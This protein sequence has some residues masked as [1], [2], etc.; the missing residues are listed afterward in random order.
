MQLRS[1]KPR[2]PSHMPGFLSHM[3]GF[4]SPDPADLCKSDFL[5]A[6]IFATSEVG[7]QQV[8]LG[9]SH[10]RSHL[11][12]ATGRL[13]A[14]RLRRTFRAYDYLEY[15]LRDV[16]ELT[17]SPSGGTV[18]LHRSLSAAAVDQV[19]TSEPSLL[20]AKTTSECVD[21]YSVKP[22]GLKAAA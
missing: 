13:F 14:V 1:T 6:L 8:R 19:A 12:T 2:H 16:F 9:L 15:I 18:M 20:I 3:P 17:E 11:R 10:H 22:S 4:P 7:L 21:T 5:K